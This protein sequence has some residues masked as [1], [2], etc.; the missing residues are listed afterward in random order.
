MYDISVLLQKHRDFLAEM[1]EHFRSFFSEVSY[2]RNQRSIR[3]LH[4]CSREALERDLAE[5]GF[6]LIASD[7]VAGKNPCRLKFNQ[8]ARFS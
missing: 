6:Y 4:V 8:A 7:L 2:Q 3:I 5:S 1:A